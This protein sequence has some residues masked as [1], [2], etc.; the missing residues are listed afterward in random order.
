MDGVRKM[1]E[2]IAKN[3]LPVGTIPATVLSVDMSNLTCD[4]KPLDGGADI[5]SVRLKSDLDGGDNG[6]VIIPKTESTVL[7]SMVMNNDQYSFVSMFSQ[8]EEIWLNGANY[9]GIVKADELKSQL[10][11]TNKVINALVSALTE[12]TPAPGDGG[13]ALKVYFASLIAGKT[14]GDYSDIKNEKVKHGGE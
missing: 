7:V 3:G 2:R 9:N 4:V 8:V 11:K 12:W 5:Y 10:D 1:I 14:V 13:A 6:F